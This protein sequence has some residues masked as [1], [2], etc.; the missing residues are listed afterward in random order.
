[1]KVNRTEQ[2]FI[3]KSHPL[4]EVVDR[5]CLYSKN[6]YNQA[7]FQMRQAYIKENK[8]LSPYDVQKIMQD[9][10]CYKECGSQAAQKTLSLI[11][12]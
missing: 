7:N 5:Y 11:H 8:V 10:D 12:I 6:V 9:M 4:Y 1:M 3:H 2:Q